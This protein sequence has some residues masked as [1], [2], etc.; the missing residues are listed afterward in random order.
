MKEPRGLPSQ[1]VLKNMFNYDPDTGVLTRRRQANGPTHTAA[2]GTVVG[3]PGAKGYLTARAAGQGHYYLHR[4]IWK[5]MTGRDPGDTIDHVNGVKT[6]NR[7][8]NLRE[9]TPVQQA[10]N[11]RRRK[12]AASG[13]TGVY[14]LPA[15]RRQWCAVLAG[16]YIGVFSTPEEANAA[17]QFAANQ[18]YGR[19]FH[20]AS[21]GK[22]YAP[23]FVGTVEKVERGGNYIRNTFIQMKPG[24]YTPLFELHEG[25]AAVRLD[26]Y[27][28][29]PIEHYK[30]LL[31]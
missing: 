9:A 19:E 1:A 21:D 24:Q 15:G 13:Y 12:K 30:R 31:K 23:P 22:D 11:T 25:G 4:I 17:R 6:D 8:S 18:H 10:G 28:I 27:A 2:A 14:K 29:I 3:Y 7:W 20:R 26:G 5:W 16:R